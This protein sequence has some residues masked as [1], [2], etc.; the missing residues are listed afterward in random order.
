M[1]LTQPTARKGY[2]FGPF[3][4]LLVQRFPEH[5]TVQGV[6][7]VRRVCDDLDVSPETGYRMLRSNFL[8]ATKAQKLLAVHAV[9]VK[10]LRR[11]ATDQKR[12]KE[13]GVPVL[14][15]T[16]LDLVDFVIPDP[17]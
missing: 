17:E 15:L 10:R 4:D 16:K 12:R 11:S 5:R 13:G 9:E 7:D 3:Y 6:L 1:A 14:P 8:P 2:S